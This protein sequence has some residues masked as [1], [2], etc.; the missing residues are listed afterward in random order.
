MIE[1][2]LNNYFDQYI[3]ED[4]LNELYYFEWRKKIDKANDEF[5]SNIH[6][7]KIKIYRNL[8]SF[9]QY[10]SIVDQPK[11]KLYIIAALLI[12]SCDF[13]FKKKINIYISQY[14]R[15]VDAGIYIVPSRLSIMRKIR[16]IRFKINN[17]ISDK[18]WYHDMVEYTPLYIM[19]H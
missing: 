5:I 14:R 18:F 9:Q 13:Y 16:F 17:F 8:S 3:T 6:I 7:T 11:M 1:T 19:T 4:I 10:E 12:N 2:I 15:Y